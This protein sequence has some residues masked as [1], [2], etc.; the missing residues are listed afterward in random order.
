MRLSEA[1]EALEEFCRL[2]PASDGEKIDDL[3]EQPG[4]P[5]AGAFD[6]VDESPQPLDIAVMSD[7]QQRPARNVTH[8]R[9]LDDDRAWATAREP[10]VPGDDRVGD[11]AV[12][13]RAPRHHRRDPRSLLERQPSLAKRRKQARVRRLILG[14][15][16]ALLGEVADALGRTPHAA[17]PIPARRRSPGSP[18]WRPPRSRRTPARPSSPGSACP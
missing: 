14:R 8:A 6:G 15:N 5:V 9:R 2:R 18:P 1:Q 11:E 3:D 16:I 13:G 4:A 17:P 7:A 10:L 12:V